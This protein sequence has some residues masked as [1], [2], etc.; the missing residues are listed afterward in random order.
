MNTMKQADA[1][2]RALAADEIDAVT[3]AGLANPTFRF[4]VF[5]YGFEFNSRTV[6]A[7]TP[8]QDTCTNIPK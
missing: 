1:A 2:V 7:I 3:G 5:G 4:T 8:T 6:C